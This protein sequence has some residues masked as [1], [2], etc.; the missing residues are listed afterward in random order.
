MSEKPPKRARSE[1]IRLF[2]QMGDVI[3]IPDIILKVFIIIWMADNPLSLQ[4][5]ENVLKEEKSSIAKTTISV[6]LKELALLG[7]IEKVRVENERANYYT[8]DMEFTELFQMIFSK[9]QY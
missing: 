8:T 4:D 2:L 1:I 5:I 6:S 9:I 3:G 7:A